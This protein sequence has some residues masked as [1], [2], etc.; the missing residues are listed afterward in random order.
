V[1][2]GKGFVPWYAFDHP[3]LGPVELGGWDSLYTWSNPPHALLEREVAKFPRWLVWHLLIS[4]RLELLEASAQ[5]LGADAW[6][7]RLVVHNTGWLPSYVTKRAHNN[8]LTRGVVCEIALPEGAALRTG[9]LRE[10]A[11]QL[12]GR[13]Y[14][15]ATPSSWGGWSGDTTDERAKVEWVVHAPQGGVVQLSARHERAGSVLAEVLLR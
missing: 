11:G 15:P 5:P 7:V 2:G 1:L 3:Q 12:E 4:P 13:A 8:K 14:K 10:D 6:R 9:R